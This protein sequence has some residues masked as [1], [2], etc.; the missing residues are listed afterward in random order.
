MNKQLNNSKLCKAQKRASSSM[1][2][3]G[4]NSLN[5]SYSTT[6]FTKAKP[7]STPLLQQISTLKTLIYW[8]R[9]L[10]RI[11]L[12]IR[13]SSSGW[14]SVPMR[15]AEKNW[16]CWKICSSKDYKKSRPGKAASVRSESN[17]TTNSSTKSSD[18]RQST[19]PSEESYWWKSE[20]TWKWLSQPTKL[21]TKDH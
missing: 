16:I 6:V 20:T 17:Y 5:S 12:S 4:S 13:V 1:T 7:F 14:M 3:N 10:S 19:F 11:F 18:R 15:P 21:C 8:I 9:C 2:L